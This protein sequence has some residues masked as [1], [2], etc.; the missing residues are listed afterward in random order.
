VG[1]LTHRFPFRGS[2]TRCRVPRNCHQAAVASHEV[3][4]ST[5]CCKRRSCKRVGLLAPTLTS[6]FPESL[7]GLTPPPAPDPLR[8]RVHPSMSF[9]SPTEY[10]LLRTCPACCH[11]R[12]PLLGFPSPSRYQYAESTNERTSQFSL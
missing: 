9:T 10:E 5:K 1:C 7:C 6:L 3:G 8:D 4:V 12:T 2:R 11:T